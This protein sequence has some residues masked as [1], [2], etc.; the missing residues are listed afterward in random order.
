MGWT[1]YVAR[2]ELAPNHFAGTAY[3]LPLNLTDFRGS[4]T[5]LKVKNR[6]ISGRRAEIVYFGR[7]KT[8][9]VMLEPMPDD[10]SNLVREFLESTADGQI[11]TFDP[12]GQQPAP[13]RQMSVQREDERHTE[14]PFLG[15]G[16]RYDWIVFSF[17]IALVE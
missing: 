14:E 3:T 8:W 15:A 4:G 5:D 12:W 11:F 9:H 7:V 1:T 6:V 10:E 2:R 13:A 17:D 16:G